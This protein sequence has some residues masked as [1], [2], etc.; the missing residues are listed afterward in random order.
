M[1]LRNLLE[2]LLVRGEVVARFG[3]ARLVKQP[4]GRFQ[5]IGGNEAERSEAR[6]WVSLFLHEAVLVET[7]EVTGAK[8]RVA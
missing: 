1:K 5:L 6:E 7:W 4:E 8:Q 2:S 3:A